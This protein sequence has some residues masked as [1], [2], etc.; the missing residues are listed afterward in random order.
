MF[1]AERKAVYIKDDAGK[2]TDAATGQADRGRRAGR[3]RQCPHQQSAARSASTPRS[4][5]LR[6]WP[7]IPVARY[8][9]AQA[10]FK[11]REASA[12]PTLDKAIAKEQDPRVKRALMEARAAV[13]L[14][15]DRRQG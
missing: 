4:A 5:G 12:L 7:A 13:I 2:L 11:S 3:S 6:C 10:V 15:S 9:A 14:F 8:E 1:S